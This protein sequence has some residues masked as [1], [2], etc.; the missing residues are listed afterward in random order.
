MGA[1]AGAVCLWLQ[2]RL[3]G[4]PLMTPPDLAEATALQQTL[5]NLA[6]TLYEQRNASVAYKLHTVGIQTGE[7]FGTKDFIDL[8]SYVRDRPGLYYLSLSVCGG[9][10][11]AVGLQVFEEDRYYLFD[12]DGG[13]SEFSFVEL[14]EYFIL[15]C[16]DEKQFAAIKVVPDSSNSS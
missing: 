12:P 2:Q 15:E 4:Q 11:H 14:V 3:Q 1:C 5:T 8:F 7:E 10:L 16:E 6:P 9:E 13:L